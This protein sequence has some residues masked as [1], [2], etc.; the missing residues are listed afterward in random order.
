[1]RAV[2]LTFVAGCLFSAAFAADEPTYGTRLDRP[3]G[4]LKSPA[5]E[6]SSICRKDHQGLDLVAAE[7]LAN[8]ETRLTAAIDAGGDLISVE[9]EGLSCAY[10][11][12][13][14]EKAFSARAEIAAAY[15][16]PHTSTLTVVTENGQS[17]DDAVIRKL[18]KRRGYGAGAIRRG[19]FVSPISHDAA[20]AAKLTT[21]Q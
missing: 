3:A 5:V 2:V 13:A 18:I 12:G 17:I 14:I 19:E 7:P 4:I 16:N 11:V 21:P 8:A 20:K 1:M 10:C 15:V 6:E 9:V